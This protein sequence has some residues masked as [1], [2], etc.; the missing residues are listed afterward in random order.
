MFLLK[1]PKPFQITG[2]YASL[3][4]WDAVKQSPDAEVAYFL[5]VQNIILRESLLM[6]VDAI[7]E[8]LDLHY[9]KYVIL[10]LKLAAKQQQM[11]TETL[12]ENISIMKSLQSQLTV[13][14]AHLRGSSISVIESII[15]WRNTIKTF[16]SI[17]TKETVS[18]FWE[19]EN[20]L[21]KISKDS[22]DLCKKFYTLKLWL[23]FNPSSLL[24]H[25]LEG[26]ESNPLNFI[27]AGNRSINSAPHQSARSATLSPSKSVRNHSG[28][29]LSPERDSIRVQ[30]R[31][32]PLRDFPHRPLGFPEKYGNRSKISST[33]SRSFSDNVL[34]II[35][36]M[37][38]LLFNAKTVWENDNLIHYLIWTTKRLEKQREEDRQKR[39]L[40]HSSASDTILAQDNTPSDASVITDL[41]SPSF[42]AS[43]IRHL[44]TFGTTDNIIFP[45]LNPV[46]PYVHPIQLLQD[47]LSH[48]DDSTALT[49][50]SGN[51]NLLEENIPKK[52]KMKSYKELSFFYSNSE[53]HALLPS[54]LS[55]SMELFPEHNIPDDVLYSEI[56]SPN[57]LT[58]GDGTKNHIVG[59]IPTIPVSQNTDVASASHSTAT[60]NTSIA[61]HPH[62]SSHPLSPPPHHQQHPHQ[63]LPHLAPHTPTHSKTQLNPNKI[64]LAPT[65]EES[66]TP[67]PSLTIFELKSPGGSLC[68]LESGPS[69]AVQ[70]KTGPGLWG[71]NPPGDTGNNFLGDD[72]FSQGVSVG[73]ESSI[74]SRAECS[75]NSRKSSRRMSMCVGT[76]RDCPADIDKIFEDTDE[77]IS[78]LRKLM[79]IA[80]LEIKNMESVGSVYNVNS[81]SSGSGGSEENSVEILSQNTN[82]NSEINKNKQSQDSTHIPNNAFVPS[83]WRN[84]HLNPVLTEAVIG[85][86]DFYP[87]KPI[88]PILPTKLYNYCLNLEKYAC[89]EIEIYSELLIT[90]E[91]AQILKSEIERSYNGDI[92]R[93]R[94]FVF[95]CCMLSSI[96]NCYISVALSFRFYSLHFI[97]Y[98]LLSLFNVL[99]THLIS[100]FSFSVISLFFS[101]FSQP[102]TIRDREPYSRIKSSN[103]L[104]PTPQELSDELSPERTYSADRSFKKTCDTDVFEKNIRAAI[105]RSTVKESRGLGAL[106]DVDVGFDID[107]DADKEGDTSGGRDTFLTGM[108]M[109]TGV[110]TGNRD[111]QSDTTHRNAVTTVRRSSFL[112]MPDSARDRMSEPWNVLSD[113]NGMFSRTF[114]RTLSSSRLHAIVDNTVNNAVNKVE[115]KVM[116]SAPRRLMITSDI[117]DIMLRN[118]LKEARAAKKE[119][120]SANSNNIGDRKSL[121]VDEMLR[122]ACAA[123]IQK[124]ARRHF[125]RRVVGLMRHEG[126]HLVDRCC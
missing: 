54:V 77:W 23:G 68:S 21:I 9:W 86:A 55:G 96:F 13:A 61:S 92:I 51:P 80:L 24:L 10:K 19:G 39:L 22:Q 26:V 44:F 90:S 25:P 36:A 89:E 32:Y 3:S 60:K 101:L 46:K 14:L 115:N 120:G 2:R 11:K 106:A 125:V 102:S 73:G 95:L 71:P 93:V 52:K 63:S 98:F 15:T 87:K 47:K 66:Q 105:S 79:D 62:F 41:M 27:F 45:E 57:S 69:S 56:S 121:D 1:A 100:S 72:S 7:G 35:S 108:G 78:V 17:K 50:C 18:I 37:E 58:C 59:Q 111:G 70:I 97:I 99:S 91:K 29:S 124:Y 49:D 112:L 126:G 109:G 83:F 81:C 114:S 65:H 75:L 88:V 117:L 122:Y 84:L 20:Y 31:I 33:I 5:V 67:N 94:I 34:H 123:T 12:E 119:L 118:R 110:G 38:P 85:L 107:V 28:I 116:H 48:A 40:G 42:P 64:R 74:G 76:T 113:K 53:V 8:N 30:N 43:Y 6:K 4:K 82:N 16:S 104:K 103:Q